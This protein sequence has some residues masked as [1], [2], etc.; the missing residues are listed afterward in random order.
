MPPVRRRILITGASSGLGEAMA[1]E[2][3]RRGRD[4]ALCARRAD[5]L[6]RLRGELA[7][8]HPEVRV[9]VRPLDVDRH[10]DVFAAVGECAE[11]LGGLDRVVVNAGIGVSRRIGTGRFAENRRTVQTNLVSALAQCE[12]AVEIFRRQGAGHLVTIS[13]VSAARGLPGH[14]TAYAA[15]K[16]GLSA[17]TEGIRA[18]L[19][20]T[21]IAVTCIEPGFIRT[22]LNADAGR[23]PFEV[24]AATGARAV[25]DAM[26]REVALARLPRWP[27]APVSLALRH[28]PIRLVARIR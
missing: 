12:A 23:L 10:D 2:L 1:R 25:V 26:E 7:E 16:A 20:S 9:V 6:E 28:L 27:W 22:E 8:R 17:L 13:S 11:R 19:L 21:P 5:R 18:E 4:L 3:A 15:S 14:L 24:D